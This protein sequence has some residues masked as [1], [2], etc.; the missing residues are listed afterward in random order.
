[1]SDFN[2]SKQLENQFKMPTPLGTPRYM[3]PG[4]RYDG[5]WRSKL[6]SELLF[7][8]IN[9]NLITPWNQKNVQR[10]RISS[11][12]RWFKFFA[13]KILYKSGKPF[14]EFSPDIKKAVDVRKAGGI[15]P[16]VA[17]FMELLCI[18]H[19]EPE[20]GVSD[21]HRAFKESSSRPAAFDEINFF[22]KIKK[23][24]ALGNVENEVRK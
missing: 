15:D 24:L 8:S 3:G 21:L 17:Q 19:P 20:Y 7:F 4:K 22:N 16:D 18:Y 1:M 5:R 6:C 14:D 13:T 9:T 11:A 2:L 12:I 10:Q 23:K